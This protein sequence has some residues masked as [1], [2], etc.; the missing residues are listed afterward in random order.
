K[1]L[2]VIRVRLASAAGTGYSYTTSKVPSIIVSCLLVAPWPLPRF[3]RSRS[4]DSSMHSSLPPHPSN[5]F[6]FLPHPSLSS[7]LPPP[8]SLLA[9]PS[10][11]PPRPALRPRRQAA[12]AQV[13]PRAAAA[14][15]V[16]RGEDLAPPRAAAQAPIDP[17]L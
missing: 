4:S 15:L 14:R 8:F 13:R 16:R 10:S 12:P 1:K 11:S 3:T 17:R 2:R 9:H 6:P 7:L 5:P